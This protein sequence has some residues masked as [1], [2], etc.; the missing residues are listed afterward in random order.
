MSV[1]WISL[2]LAF[3]PNEAV[4]DTQ[5]SPVDKHTSLATPGRQVRTDSIQAGS[6]ASQINCTATDTVSPGLK[7]APLGP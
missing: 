7:P 3:V 2:G 5:F 1:A 6:A 4:T